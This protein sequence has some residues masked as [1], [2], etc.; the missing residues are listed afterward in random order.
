MF[1]ELD[2]RRGD[3][4]TVT[5]EWNR[6]TGQTQIV[7]HDIRADRLI[8]FGVPPA[9]AAH[10]FRHPF[11]YA[12]WSG[13]PPAD[14][15]GSTPP[16]LLTGS[17]IP[18]ATRIEPASPR[19]RSPSR[20]PSEAYQSALDREERAAKTYAGLMRRVRHLTETGLAHQLALIQAPSGA[21]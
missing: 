7:L 19:A 4:L 20:W 16:S 15:L 12:P 9:N 2:T 14:A 18:S 8:A 1:V 10:A 3:G 5:L 6:D 17:G 21:F 11:S 13:A